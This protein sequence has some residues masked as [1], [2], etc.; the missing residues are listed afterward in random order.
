MVNMGNCHGKTPDRT[1]SDN[2]AAS[3]SQFVGIVDV[4]TGDTGNTEG[5]GKFVTEVASYLTLTT[6]TKIATVCSLPAADVDRISRNM[7]PGLV[8]MDTLRQRGK[9]SPNDI[10]SLI[11]ALEHIGLHGIAPKVTDLFARYV[12]GNFPSP[13]GFPN[14]RD[15]LSGK[16]KQFLKDILETYA[17]MYNGVQT[18][19]YI[20]ERL[21]CVN[22]VFV[23]SG[24]EYLKKED[25]SN[26]GGGTWLKLD[27]YNSIFTDP[28]LSHAMVFLLYGEPGYGKSTLALEYVYDWCNRC[29]GSPL[30]DIEMLIFLRLRYLRGGMPILKAIKEFLLPSDTALSERD[31]K[32]IIQSCASVVLVFDG[33][34]EYS[35]RGDNS[36]DDVA[37]IV[38]RQM[39]RKYKLVLTTRPSGTP[40]KLS[41]STQKVRLTG[42]DDQ[43]KERYILKA[44]V[45]GNAEA[46]ARILRQLQ[47]N[48]ILADIC[49]VNLFFVMFVHMTH[50][51]ETSLVLDS[52]TSFFRYVIACFYEHIQIKVGAVSTAFNF[53]PATKHHKLDKVAFESLQG[54]DQHLVW[55]RDRFVE[56]IDEPLYNELVEIG[57]LVEENVVRIVNKPGTSAADLIQRRKDV[58]FYHKLFCEWY[59]AH[60]VAEHINSLGPSSLQRFFENMD[61]FDLQ[62]VY[63]IACGLNPV[64][65][66]K[67]I[68]YLHSIEGGDKFAILC[69]LEQTGQVDN[70]KDTIRQM[71]DEGVIISGYDSLLLQRSSMQLLEI[72]ARNEIPIEYL[73][74]SNCLQSV[75]LSTASIRTTSGLA[76]TSRIPVKELGVYLYNREMTEDEAID[77]LQFASMC[78]SLR[79]LLYYGCVPPRS[80]SVGPILSTLKS[81]NVE[82]TW[83]WADDAPWYILN[84]QSGRW[85]NED[86]DSEPEEEVF[87][88]ALAMRAEWRREWTKETYIERVSTTCI[89]Q[90]E[91]SCKNLLK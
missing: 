52:V 66:D 53:T 56:L 3:Y 79:L 50:E 87:E 78:R 48:P 15:S 72:A 75:D 84:L 7:D 28:R 27:S 21:L 34:D 80:F 29:S 30:K 77:I 6:A 60:Y 83:R 59:A 10:S 42:F 31:V 71:C 41:H 90:N 73:S 37:K 9:I 16:K 43:A 14:P 49:Q 65:A 24:I 19:P 91:T 64:A 36:K 12:S 70:M 46:A 11:D 69:I 67:I 89:V 35:N 1:R 18:I 17:E 86:G 54:K 61:P 23:D 5:F 13:G 8:L 55:S 85:E 44:V 20:R 62:Y 45:N 22:K 47:Q 63:R 74:L 82:V 4:S 25:G 32:D 26:A 33:F 38:A 58:S 76:L 57:I 88:E 81:R 51:K 39:F 40:T 2:A 68:Q